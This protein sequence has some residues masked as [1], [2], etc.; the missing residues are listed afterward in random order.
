MEKYYDVIIVGG[1]PAGA[2]LAA[3]LGQQGVRT[4]VVERA[5]FP[6]VPAASSPIIYSPALK[7]L[8]ETGVKESE[9]AHNTPRI[10]RIYAD[11]SQFQLN[12]PLPD[13]NGR[14]YAYAIDR[15]RFDAALLDHASRYPSVDTRLEYAVTDLLWEEGKVVGIVGQAHGGTEEHIRAG[16]VVGADGRF[17]LVARKVNAAEH[18]V[19]SD[20]PT[21]L[22]YAYWKNVKPYPEATE[23][24]AVAYEGGYGYGLLVMD[25]ADGTTAVTM[26]GQADLLEAPAGKTTEFYLEKLQANPKVTARLEGAAM[27]TKVHGMRKIGNMYRQPGGAGWAL[28]GDAYHQ[29]DPLDGQGIF[30]ALFTAKSLA[31]AI[32]YYRRGQMSWDEALEWYDE[33][34][35]SKTYGMYRQTLDNVKA[36]LYNANQQLPSWALTGL[37]W[38]MEDPTTVD[39]FGKLMTRQIPP[40]VVR[41]ATPA[42]AIGALVR[43]P[44]RE[45]RKRLLTFGE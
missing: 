4:L 33:T 1:R 19:H 21:S 6:S 25:S 5:E 3:R 30:N 18:D 36:N 34:T 45:I 11:N 32:R 35:R 43:A 42:I 8:D 27:V 20:N 9:Y 44:L 23:P 13:V 39:L 2:S 10:R 7:L 28:V 26:E 41:M 22:L 38:V 37:R 12:I 40:E 31:W 16:I 17:S 15:A 14:D 29:H 24:S